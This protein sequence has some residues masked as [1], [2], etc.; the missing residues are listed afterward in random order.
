MADRPCTS[1]NRES[2]L[3]DIFEC[4]LLSELYEFLSVNVLFIELF[5]LIHEFLFH[6][7]FEY[8][9]TSLFAVTT[10]R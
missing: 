8:M 6:H 7:A 4:S 10:F 9:E 2:L 5:F 3:T 1:S